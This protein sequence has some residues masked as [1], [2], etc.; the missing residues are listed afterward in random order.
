MSLLTE[1][2]LRQLAP[3]GLEYGRGERYGGRHLSVSLEAFK[4]ADRRGIERLYGALTALQEQLESIDRRDPAR[5]R[6]VLS[7][8]LDD[9]GWRSLLEWA[10]GIG[11]PADPDVDTERFSQVRHDL[12][13]GALAQLVS[14]LQLAEA[15]KL[16]DEQVS[17]IYLRVRDHTKIMRN[18]IPD[19]D[20]KAYQ[21]DSQEKIHEA[22]L[23]VEKWKRTELIDE[24]G[25][26]IDVSVEAGYEGPI[27]DRCVEFAALD[28]V[29]Y[30][31]MNNA[32]EGT[33][34]GR[35]ELYLTAVPNGEPRHLRIAVA[36]R[37]SDERARTLEES[38]GGRDLSSLFLDDYTTSGSGL[39]LRICGTFVGFAYGV[40]AAGAVEQGHVGARLIDG[41]FVNWVHW[42]M[43]SEQSQPYGG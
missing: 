8:F 40:G 21:R 38:F 29:V 12:K 37:I 9:C 28:R 34:D 4:E 15:G 33:A 23:I 13:G 26:P 43:V 3:S 18:A 2:K 35:I 10:R 5:V 31:M 24:E 41:A 32:V 25:R 11:E 30:N 27:S 20:P 22:A 7:D 39:G 1:Q 36:N 14:G 17:K 42:P 6:S 19:L 16:D